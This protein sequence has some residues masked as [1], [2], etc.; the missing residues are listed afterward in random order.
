MISFKV[1]KSFDVSDIQSKLIEAKSESQRYLAV[2]IINDCKPYVPRFYGDL[3]NSV[4]YV[5][6]DVAAYVYW[7]I[8]YARK[9]YYASYMNFNRFFNKKATAFWFEY[10]KIDNLSK[11]IELASSSFERRF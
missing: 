2:L 9:V 5:Y 8:Y 6:N 10:A 11:W 3:C 4:N 7:D 1:S